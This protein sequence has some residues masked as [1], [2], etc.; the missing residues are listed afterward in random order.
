MVRADAGWCCLLCC[1]GIAAV[2]CGQGTAGAAETRGLP[3]PRHTIDDS[4]RGADGVRLADVN[5]DGLID[6]ATGWEE[7]GRIRVY[8][9]PGAAAVTDQ[10]PAV[11]VGKVKSPED[12]VFVDL[13]DDGA[14]D[15]VS[16]CEGR[17][18]TVFVHWAPSHQEYLQPA[19]WQT[20]PLP[21]TAEQQAWMFALPMQIDGRHGVDLVVGSKGSNAT[22]GWLESPEDPREV[23]GWRFHPLYRAGWIMSLQ[24][25]DMDGDGDLDVV[26]TD[27]KG[28]TRGLLWLEN[29]GPRAATLRRVDGWPKHRLGG[30]DREVMFLAVGPLAKADP[31]RAGPAN[32]RPTKAGVG[33]IVAAVRGGGLAW[34]RQPRPDAAWSLTEI[35]MPSGCGTGKG[36]ALGDI[37]LDGQVDLVFSCEH[38]EPPLSGVRWLSLQQSPPSD[39]SPAA[40]HAWQ[41]HEISG[42]RGIKFD[43]LE[44]IDL[45]RDGDL[46]VLTCEERHNLGVFWYENPVRRRR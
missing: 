35:A 46:D 38:A 21:C 23:T 13:D 39:P 30:D 5:G 2:A 15:V 20:T 1:L 16:C 29:P 27:R 45:D 32:A 34:F 43:R 37:D 28:A 25:H 9:H 22:V 8:L 26:A 42:S 19:A 41:D 17:T 44:L 10:W 14:I 40:N 18:K 3:W 11:T 6:I 7:G 33:D 12:A 36:V 24:A 4:S 31:L